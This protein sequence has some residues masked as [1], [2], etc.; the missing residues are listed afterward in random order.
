MSIEALFVIH[1]GCTQ[2]HP[3]FSLEQVPVTW[4]IAALGLTMT[5]HG[6]DHGQEHGHDNED[7]YF[8][9]KAKAMTSK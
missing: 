9:E 2:E 6:H 1:H 5:G 8:F 3:K 4:E 7:E